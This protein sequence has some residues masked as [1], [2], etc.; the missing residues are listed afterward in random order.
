MI[1]SS[2]RPPSFEQKISLIAYLKEVQNY[3]FTSVETL[4]ALDRNP[5][6]FANLIKYNCEV[7]SHTMDHPIFELCTEEDSDFKVVFLKDTPDSGLVVLLFNDADQER[8]TCL[9]LTKPF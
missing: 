2:L 7:E 4:R 3:L 9:D 6:L 8:A 1:I 5:A